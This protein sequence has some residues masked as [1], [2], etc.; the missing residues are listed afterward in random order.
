MTGVV[1]DKLLN[2]AFIHRLHFTFKNNNL[3]TRNVVGWN[4]TVHIYDGS[5]NIYSLPGYNIHSKFS[6]AFQHENL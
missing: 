6:D 3:I 2:Y 5:M 4:I 1:V